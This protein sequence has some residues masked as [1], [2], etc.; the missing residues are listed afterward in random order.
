MKKHKELISLINECNGKV[1]MFK[2]LPTTFKYAIAYY[3][4]IDGEAW[5]MPSTVENTI[6]I[7][8]TYQNKLRE[9]LKKNI[10]FYT[11]KYGNMKFGVV[12]I[13]TEDFLNLFGKWKNRYDNR[14]VLEKRKE[15][16]PVILDLN[17][18]DRSSD[19][20][21]IIQDGWTRFGDYVAMGLKSIP[22]VYYLDRQKYF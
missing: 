11:K 17:D 12:N 18:W 7:S 1:M 15:F 6:G 20:V 5:E 3:M 19:D 9:N 21:T 10:G 14:E 22:C 13:P 2:N 8:K 16:W 4:S